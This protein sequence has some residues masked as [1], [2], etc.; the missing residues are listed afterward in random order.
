MPEAA[1]VRIR[2]TE[3]TSGDS[4]ASEDEDSRGEVVVTN[5]EMSGSASDS[6]AAT[7]KLNSR[8]SLQGS[9]LQNSI[10][11]ENFSYKISSSNL[12]QLSTQ[13]ITDTKLSQFC[14]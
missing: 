3:T 12:G 4:S 7:P 11:A 2:D 14:G 13:K 10:S 9:I 1:K 8:P 5:G 6:D